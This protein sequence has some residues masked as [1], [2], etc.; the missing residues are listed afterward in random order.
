MEL[1]HETLVTSVGAMKKRAYYLLPDDKM[2]ELTNCKFSFFEKFTPE[3]FDAEAKDEM[4]VPSCWNM[5]GYD[6]H[7]Y[8]NVRYPFP[9]DP[10]HIWKD[11]P[12]GV[13]EF[14]YTL[15]TEEGKHY[16]SFEGVDNC[17]YLFVNG[18]FVGYAS[19]SHALHEFDVTNF[20][21][22]ENKIRVVVLKWSATSYLE[23]QD[24]LRMSGIF[25]KV[26]V[27][28]RPQGHVYDYA[29]KSD[30]VDG[31]GVITFNADAECEIELFDGEVSL[32]KQTGTEAEFVVENPVLWNAEAP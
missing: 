30:I 19:I 13:Y 5:K 8:T 24:K 20:L 11:I 10:P 14:N 2:D 7:Q 28:H 15:E 32:G 9:Y 6:Y 22:K 23:D 3:V 27:I 17:F 4:V 16:L 26:R 25:G 21:Q 12:C 1:Y 18:A 31:K 29:L